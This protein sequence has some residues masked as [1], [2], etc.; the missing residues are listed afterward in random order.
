MVS[1]ESTSPA[2]EMERGMD[3][4]TLAIGQ[5]QAAQKAIV[6]RQDRNEAATNAKF[7]TIDNK[8]NTADA[9]LDTLLEAQKIAAAVRADSEKR[10]DRRAKGI[11]AW[12]SLASGLVVTVCAELARWLL[13]HKTG[14]AP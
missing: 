11:A 8:L 2:S 13:F 9:K 12:S 14:L 3:M 4:A 7:Q 1:T 6:E 5:L 10:Q